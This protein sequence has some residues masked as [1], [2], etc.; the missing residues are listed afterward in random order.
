MC[1]GYVTLGQGDAEEGVLVAIVCDGFAE[2]DVE[3]RGAAYHEVEGSEALVGVLAAVV[4]STALV[5]TV[6]IGV[7]QAHL[8]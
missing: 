5:G 6:L 8:G 1:D 3:E 7:A 2:E 4:G